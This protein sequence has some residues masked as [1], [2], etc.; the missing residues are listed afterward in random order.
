[1]ASFSVGKPSL[2]NNRFTYTVAASNLFFNTL[3]NATGTLGISLEYTI[4]DAGTT[5]T[6]SGGCTFK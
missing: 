3:K 6:G 5:C 2:Q 4:D 1:M